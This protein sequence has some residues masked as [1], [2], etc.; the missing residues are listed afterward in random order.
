V[1]LL[2][3]QG[4]Y[5]YTS[6]N[7]PDIHE[8]MGRSVVI[9]RDPDHGVGAGCDQDGNAGPGLLVGIIGVANPKTVPPTVP[10]AVNN[11]FASI[12]CSHW[13]DAHPGLTAAVI[14]GWIL[15]ALL[16]VL[17]LGMLAYYFIRLKPRVGYEEMH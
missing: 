3:P 8:I 11:N 10:V 9:D 6:S 17:V 16:L 14:M 1:I 13:T 4:W 15:A 2:S 5:Q 7:I 12:D